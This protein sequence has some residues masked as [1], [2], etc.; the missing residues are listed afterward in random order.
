M[1]LA[2]NAAAVIHAN[3]HNSHAITQAGF[4]LHGSGQVSVD[5]YMA[6]SWLTYYQSLFSSWTQ[7]LH[8]S[9]VS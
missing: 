2:M 6:R 3:R 5:R 9:T 8:V 1:N 7:V 4:R